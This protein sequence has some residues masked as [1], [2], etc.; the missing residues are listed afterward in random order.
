MESL[1]QR[2]MLAITSL[3][4][5][6]PAPER[7]VSHMFSSEGHVYFIEDGPVEPTRQQG[8]TFSWLWR[9]DGT[10]EGTDRILFS[11]PSRN[12]VEY[13]GQVGER[14]AFRVQ[15]VYELGLGHEI[16]G[17]EGAEIYRLTQGMSSTSSYDGQH[18]SSPFTASER[19]WFEIYSVEQHVQWII[20]TD[21]TREGTRSGPTVEIGSTYAAVVDDHVVH[22]SGYGWIRSSGA[23]MNVLHQRIGE[24]AKLG[25][26]LVVAA[27]ER[28][29]YRDHIFEYPAQ[30]FR[31]YYWTRESVV[32]IAELPSGVEVFAAFNDLLLFRSNESLWVTDGSASGTRM[33]VQN[34]DPQF[35]G[36]LG[37]EF[38]FVGSSDTSGRELWRTD[39]TAAGTQ[40][41]SDLHAGP[42]STKFANMPAQVLDD[43]LYF[44]ADD[45][46]SGMELWVTDGS[47]DGTR[48]VEETIP[49]PDN[50]DIQ[51]FT[52]TND[53]IVMR[54]AE[55]SRSLLVMKPD[56]NPAD[57]NLDGIVDFS[58]FL[59]LA[60]S[61]GENNASYESGDFDGDELVTDADFEILARNYGR[62]QSF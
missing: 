13:G 5:A 54:T 37:D 46:M 48:L 23:P 40:L 17:I 27:L 41:L 28:G 58:D 30:P 56:P 38:I 12:H 21:G 34:I 2:R 33:L 53:M 51:G 7:T 57:A 18:S 26:G 49:G 42:G 14:H 55:A 4:Y 36:A 35:L 52:V 60:A 3:Q 29:P 59:A 62:R 39:G 47:T 45:G 9:T 61:Y 1:E 32:E 50:L 19:I 44:F 11:T 16:W 8:L 10:A 25:E 6:E 43:E 20:H 22:H 15:Y 24:T 31:L